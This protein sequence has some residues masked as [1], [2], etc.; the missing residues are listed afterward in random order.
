MA[1][2]VSLYKRAY[3]TANDLAEFVWQIA[4]FW[5]VFSQ[6]IIGNQF[7]HSLDAL[8]ID[9]AKLAKSNN[10]SQRNTYVQSAQEHLIEAFMWNDK[11]RRRKLLGK[12]EYQT[13][14]V[15][16]QKVESLLSSKKGKTK[17]SSSN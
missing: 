15:Q 2:P 13:I 10:P 6:T 14:Y 3:I 7:V 12:E 11:A 5:G 9:L 4:Q 16:I 17:V 1:N 8:S